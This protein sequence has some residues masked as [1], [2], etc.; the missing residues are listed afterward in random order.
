MRYGVPLVFYSLGA[1]QTTIKALTITN[2]SQSYF[3]TVEN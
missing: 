3:R 2:D 1:T